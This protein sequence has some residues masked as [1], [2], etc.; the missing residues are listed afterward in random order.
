LRPDRTGPPIA[1]GHR[2]ALAYAPENTIEGFARALRMGATG[3]ETDAWLAADGVPVLVHDRTIRPPGRRIFVT[4]RTSAEL[5][6]WGVPTLAR[7]YAECGTRFDLSI[8]VEHPE[9]GEPIVA[10][11]RDAGALD[12]LWLCHEDLEVLAVLRAYERRVR[13][14]SSVDLRVKPPVF[15]AHLDRMIDAGVGVLNM[16]WRTWSPAR[17]AAVHERGLLGFAWD[18]IEPATMTWLLDLGI[19]AIYSDYPDRIVQAISAHQRGATGPRPVAGS[20]SPSAAGRPAR[21]GV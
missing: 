15:Q 3:L 11:A 14:A 6:E 5:T 20:G 9:V 10:V 12:R 13:L 16:R 2:G 18:V 21:P 4:R 7:L 1:F 17:L 8:D 19:D